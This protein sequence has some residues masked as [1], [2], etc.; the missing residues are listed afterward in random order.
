MKED[1]DIY[2]KD[3][4]GRVH[5]KGKTWRVYYYILEVAVE[6]PKSIDEAEAN[7]DADEFIQ[8]RSRSMGR[9]HES[10]CSIVRIDE[11]GPKRPV[12]CP[13]VIKDYPSGEK[14]ERVVESKAVK[15]AVK[16]KTRF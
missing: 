1:I 16:K 10:F 15:K 11:C 6:S 2:N 14:T 8:S 3:K 9:I 13:V 5:K 12:N 7:E 4:G